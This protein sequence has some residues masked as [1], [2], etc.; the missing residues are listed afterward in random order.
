MAT[1]WHIHEIANFLDHWQTLL[2]SLIGGLL[3]LFAALIVAYRVEHRMDVS[4]VMHLVANTVASRAAMN[5]LEEL[6]GE[7]RNTIADNA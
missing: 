6:W 4:A 1:Y 7:Y 5:Q 2:G 3:G